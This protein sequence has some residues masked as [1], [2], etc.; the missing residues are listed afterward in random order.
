MSDTLMEE[1]RNANQIQPLVC[2]VEDVSNVRNFSGKQHNTVF[3]T[4]KL[5]DLLPGI[6]KGTR[7]TYLGAWQHRVQFASMKADQRRISAETATWGEN[8]TN[9]ILFE[10]RVMGIKASTVRNK[11][12]SLRY[13]HILAGYPDFGKW[14]CMYKQ[15]LNSIAKGDTTLR[16]YPFNLE[17]MKWA[18]EEVST[19]GKHP[20][21]RLNSTGAGIFAAVSVGFFFLLRI[22]EIEN[23]RMKDIRIERDGGVVFLN[24]HIKGSKTDQ[25]N[26]GDQKRLG[27]VGGATVSGGGYCRLSVR[28]RVGP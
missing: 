5:N 3:G 9:W 19:P 8:I 16:N 2:E 12:S 21:S 1:V 24:L 17:L 18:K 20:E 14:S 11:V 10:T 4:G 28:N 15:V 13:W 7:G 27:E 26:L 6:S 23:L 22:N 25:Y